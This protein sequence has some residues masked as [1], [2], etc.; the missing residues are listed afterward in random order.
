MD[1]ATKHYWA[2]AATEALM[3]HVRP[4]VNADGKQVPLTPLALQ[5]EIYSVMRGSLEVL[6]RLQRQRRANLLAPNAN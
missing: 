6:L 3:Q 2:S 1:E 4:Q 5:M